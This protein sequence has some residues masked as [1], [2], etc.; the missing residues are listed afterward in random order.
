ML[1]G[2]FLLM[3][4]I[5]YGCSSVTVSVN[6]LIFTLIFEEYNYSCADFTVFTPAWDL[7]H[8]YIRAVSGL[9][10]LCPLFTLVSALL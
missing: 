8:A 1:Q 5:S 7:T 4:Y 6:D 2:F 3:K 9:G 10:C